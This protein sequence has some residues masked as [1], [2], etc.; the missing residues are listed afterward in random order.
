MSIDWDRRLYA[1]SIS[2][3]YGDAIIVKVPPGIEYAM[4]PEGML[5]FRLVHDETTGLSEIVLDITFRSGI[6]IESLGLTDKVDEA[7]RWVSDANELL[8][9]AKKRRGLW[10]GKTSFD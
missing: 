2:R 8:Q 10:A 1:F 9:R 7:K 6:E 4:G 5:Q 3:E